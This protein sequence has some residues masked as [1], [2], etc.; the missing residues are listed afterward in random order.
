MSPEQLEI[1]PYSDHFTQLISRD[2]IKRADGD[3]M[4]LSGV[5]RRLLK[6]EAARDLHGVEIE[7]D[8]LLAYIDWVKVHFP[9]WLPND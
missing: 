3:M 4:R 6:A 1:L 2:E 8:Y 7:H 5:Q 9:E